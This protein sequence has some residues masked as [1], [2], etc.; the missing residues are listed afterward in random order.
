MRHLRL[1][2]YAG[3]ISGAKHYN[4]KKP[5]FKV[6]NIGEITLA[7]R[8]PIIN[9]KD[10]QLKRK[11]VLNKTERMAFCS[12]ALSRAKRALEEHHG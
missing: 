1:S 5:N 2:Y 7:K 10:H 6:T 9:T 11:L 12:G 3:L 4:S 8:P